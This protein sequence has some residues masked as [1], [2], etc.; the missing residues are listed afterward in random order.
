[1][2]QQDVKAILL[3]LQSK[4]YIESDITHTFGENNTA[5]FSVTYSKNDETFDVMFIETDSLEKFHDVD[6]AVNCITN[7]IQK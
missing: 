2:N 3:N 7:L 6:S 1:M 5:V 4:Q